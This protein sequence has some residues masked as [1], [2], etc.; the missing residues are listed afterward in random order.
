[1]IETKI[2]VCKK[3]AQNILD[4]LRIKI[5]TQNL[6]PHLAIIL[7][8]QDPASLVYVNNKIAQAAIVGIKTELIKLPYCITQQELIAHIDECNKN[9]QISG[10]IVQMPLP[11]HISLLNVT[12]AIEPSKDVDGFHMLNVGMLHSFGYWAN[13]IIP[14]FKSFAPCTA[15]ACVAAMQ[16]V[17]PNLAGKHVVIVNRSNLVGR[18][19]CALL[20]WLNATV[21]ICHSFSHDLAS[22]TKLGDIVVCAIGKAK[23]F[24]Q[25]YFKQGAIVLDV[26]ISRDDQSGKISGDINLESLLGHVSYVTTVPGGIGRL[27][28]AYLLSN[29]V[30]SF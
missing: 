3:I 22:L 30:E 28:V 13:H 27:T 14:S 16:A 26:G 8:G 18:P 25:S 9:P 12:Q 11:P 7:V 23:F 29:T 4:E 19:L 24:D 20:T 21:T 6:H 2:I 15:L 17:E 1:M 5:L 10:I